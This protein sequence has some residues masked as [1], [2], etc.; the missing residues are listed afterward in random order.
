M[1]VILPLLLLLTFQIQCNLMCLSE[2]DFDV[3][4][5]AAQAMPAGHHH[6]HSD[7]DQESPHHSG[8]KDCKHPSFDNAESV[9]SFSLLHVTPSE[10][11]L[12]LSDHVLSKFA[13]EPLRFGVDFH[14]PPLTADTPILPLRI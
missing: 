2:H 10:E 1:K 7:A 12:V 14:S 8:G 13:S 6:H 9:Q 11:A 4:K 5:T 3:Q